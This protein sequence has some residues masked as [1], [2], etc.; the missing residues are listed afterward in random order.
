MN[1]SEPATL[2]T[3]YLMAGLALAWF[4]RLAGQRSGAALGSWRSAFLLLAL[5][6]FLGG[7]Y[8][9]FQAMLPP[10]V[11]DS[12]WRATLASAALA[13]LFLMKAGV[14]QFGTRGRRAWT[15]LAYAK[16]GTALAVGQAWPDFL[17]VLADFALSVAVVAA[18]A[19][20]HLRAGWNAAAKFLAGT[21]L[22]VLG[23]TVQALG[24][25]P[26]PAFNHNDLF[27][28][29]QILGNFMFYLCARDALAPADAP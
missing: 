24:L 3:D 19:F 6:S 20:P 29:I 21:G 22:F 15:G 27:H 26:H 4:M 7:T 9:G 5:S 10:P 8:H 12:L 28:V 25:A 11:P 2:L 14:C 23:G 13:S 17:V 1:I 18:L 16:A